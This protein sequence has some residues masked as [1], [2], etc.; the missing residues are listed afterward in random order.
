MAVATQAEFNGATMGLMA[1]YFATMADVY[2]VTGDLDEAH[3]Q[4]ETADGA[5]KTA[6]ASARRLSR[7]TGYEFAA[8]DWSLWQAFAEQLKQRQKQ[9]IRQACSRQIARAG[10]PGALTL[11]GAGVGRFLLKEL[12][13][14]MNVHYRDFSEC[15]VEADDFS[16]LS[17]ADCAPAVA[18]A[19]LAG[20]FG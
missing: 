20:E 9:M 13:A 5:E 3:D 6:L 12:A 15:V 11:T 1:E 2:R 4:S 19:Y 10:N 17:A 16:G 18:V 14:E 7:M 8:D